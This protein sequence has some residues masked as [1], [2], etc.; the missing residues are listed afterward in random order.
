[1]TEET[2]KAIAANGETERS[3]VIAAAL[4]AGFM[5]STMHGQGANKMMPVSD[6]KT[7]I[8]FWQAARASAPVIDREA[9]SK[10]FDE[11]LGFYGAFDQE[12]ILHRA[13]SHLYSE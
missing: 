11:A 1:M 10:A 8:A 4:D 9:I 2:N 13:F 6:S 12:A 3:Q 5:L 7:L